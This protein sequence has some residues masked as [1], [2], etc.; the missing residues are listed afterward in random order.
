M[1]LATTCGEIDLALKA[2]AAPH[3]VNSFVFLAGKLLRPHQVPPA[4]HRRHLRAAVR[5]PDRHRHRRP[6]LH[7]PDENLK[8]EPRRPTRR[9]RVAMA[10]TGPG[11]RR[12]PVL[13]GLQGHPAARRATRRSARSSAGMDVLKKIAAAGESTGAR[14]TARQR[15]RRSQQGDRHAN[16]DLR[17]APRPSSAISAAGIRTATRRSPMLA[18]TKLW[19]MPGGA[20][21]ARASCGGG[22][23]SSDPWGRVDET[24]TVF[25]GPPTASSGR[26]LAGGFPRGSLAYFERK[27]D[28]LAVEIGLL[29]RRVQTTDLAA[30]DA[31]TAMDHLRE[32]VEAHPRSA[33]WRRCEV[34]WRAH[35]D[36]RVKRREE[37]KSSAPSSPTRPG[38]PRRSSS[39]R[40]S[41]WPQSDQW[42][43]TGERL[44][45]LLDK[46]K[47]LPRLDRGPTTSCGTGSRTPARRSPSGAR[48]TSRQ[49]D[50][51]R[52][53]ARRPKEKLVAEAEALAARPTGVRR[54]ARYRD[55]MA[56]WK[57]AGR[58]QREYEDELWKRSA[59]PRTSSSP[60]E[61]GLRRAGR[62]ADGEPDAQG[63]AGRGGR[64][65][66]AGRRP[67]GGEAALRSIHERWEAIGHVPRD[68]RPNRGPAARGRAGD[69]RGRGD[70]V[71][72]HQPGGPRACRRV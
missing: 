2:A 33:I 29:E 68:A 35:G 52:E 13:P 4:H 43:A 48:R 37:R 60:P 26:F 58:A 18:V 22:A 8:D 42:R 31:L 49:L 28:G 7:V 72:P 70:R 63:G 57:A 34:G 27:Y 23:V 51:Q 6:G 67:E 5:R 46:W 41:S 14:Q 9:A 10:N 66:A 53:E 17:T 71:A 50:E 19:T 62:R 3:T 25:V 36:R 59:A 30:K 21:A 20:A 65:A 55:L 24:G 61:H 16:P 1:T 64:G 56:E 11:T 32:Q 39:P 40:P 15:D 47:G 45:A 12:Q 69:P 44:R 54:A 38:R